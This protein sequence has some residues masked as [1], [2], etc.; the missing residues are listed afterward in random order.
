MKHLNKKPLVSIIMPVYDAGAFLRE[1][2]NS[3]LAQSYPNLEILAI[4]DGSK[5]DSLAILQSFR[6]RDKRVRVYSYKR[7]RG[8][9]FAANLGIQKSKGIFLA[10]FD[11]DDLM[12]A[13]RIEKQVDYLLGNP[14]TA[15]V[16]GQCV[17]IGENDELIGEKKFPLTD[18]EIREMSFTAMSLQAGS[19]MINRKLIPETFKFYTS[20]YRYAEDHELLFKLFQFG[21][22]ANLK[23]V[24]LYYRQ[25]NGNSTKKVNPKVVFKEIYSIRKQWFDKNIASGLKAR[26]INW[27]QYIVVMSLPEYM[28]PIL[29]AVVR[30]THALHYYFNLKF[31]WNKIIPKFYSTVKAYLF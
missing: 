2:I 4:D 31:N 30:R 20:K 9:S 19:M 8:L 28:V 15:V 22:V 11:A 13:D 21:K 5:D 23:D 25:H 24:L 17:L 18:R 7:N 3:V 12:P 26:F 6:K 10:R 16:G 27:C 29:F 14:D 1:A